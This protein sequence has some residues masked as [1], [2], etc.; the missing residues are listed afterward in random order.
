MSDSVFI[1]ADGRA[2][3]AGFT[4][5]TTLL[6][7]WESM[8]LPLICLLIKIP[9]FVYIYILDNILRNK[10]MM[11]T[12]KYDFLFKIVLFLVNYHEYYFVFIEFEYLYG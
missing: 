8:Y 6:H 10:E 1:Y 11:N 12:H 9:I 4:A 3:L 5:I 2:V 7:N